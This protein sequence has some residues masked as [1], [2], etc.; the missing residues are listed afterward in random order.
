MKDRIKRQQKRQLPK[1]QQGMVVV[2]VTAALLLLLAFM[3]FAIDVNH[4][5]VNKARLQNSVDAAALA[6]AVVLDNGEDTTAAQN[7]ANTTLATAASQLGNHELDFAN[8]NVSIQFSNDPQTFPDNSF[9]PNLDVYVR[10]HV[11]DM[12]LTG[13]FMGLFNLDKA[14]DASAVAGPSASLVILCNVV[15]IAVCADSGAGS[16]GSQ[17]LG[18]NYNET[19]AI[20]M[21]S[22]QNSPMG[23]GNFQLLD[24]GSGANTVRNALAGGY[25]GCIRLDE[26]V[27]TKPGNTVGPVAQGLNTRLNIYQGG[28][29]NSTSYPPD[30][31]VAQPSTPASQDNQ[32]NVSQPNWGY[33]D[34]LAE[35][36]NC[37]G[38]SDCTSGPAG[39]RI[40]PVP[41][42][43]CAGS[44]GGT[45]QLDV[46]ALG[47]FFLGQQV[48]NSNGQG[49]AVVF[50]EFIEDCTASNGSTGTTP[51][52]VGPNRIVLYKDPNRGD[53]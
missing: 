17:F 4:A 18:F 5:I 33:S 37:P 38:G 35:I 47:C 30:R 25:D 42:V 32:G 8:A 11:A 12:P 22:H 52:N 23:P 41:M 50:G 43:D 34:Y 31:Y 14:V 13:F 20:K 53:A 16:T 49:G 40:L 46:F 29:M 45:T 48:P 27:Q 2:M 6:A 1:Q 26:T 44:T 19:Y 39:R 21:A 51:N 28:G 9:N 3:A 24:F 10:V 36:S 15:P 7:A